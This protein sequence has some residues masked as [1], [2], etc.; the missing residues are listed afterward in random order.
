MLPIDILLNG[1]VMHDVGLNLDRNEEDLPFVVSE[2]ILEI[3]CV[4][5][6]VYQLN[7][8]RRIIDADDMQP[9]IDALKA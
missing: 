8:G 4:K 5:L 1:V 7:D 9:F 3:D 2:G 6:R